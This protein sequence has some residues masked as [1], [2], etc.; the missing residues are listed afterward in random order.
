MKH[1]TSSASSS[2]LFFNLSLSLS[3]PAKQLFVFQVALYT[4]LGG[5][6]PNPKGGGGGGAEPVGVILFHAPKAAQ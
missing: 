6:W 4:A 5:H 3:I 1:I 2:V